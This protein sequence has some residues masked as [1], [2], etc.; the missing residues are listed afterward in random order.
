MIVKAHEARPR[1]FKGVVL[2]LLAVGAQ[3]MVT[4]MR[5]TTGNRVSA[6]SHSNEQ[7]GYVLSGQFRLRFEEYDEVLQAGDSY[8]IPA[9][10]IHSVDVLEPGE[11]IDVFTPPRTDYL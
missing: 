3:S 8:S 5:Y 4:K 6:H 11:V 2:E 7:S 9:D 10:V 1:E